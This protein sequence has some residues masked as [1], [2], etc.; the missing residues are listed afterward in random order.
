MLILGL[1]LLLPLQ[2]LTW[3][4]LPR[5]A[6]W[7]PMAFHRALCSVCAV[8]VTVVGTLPTSRPLLIVANHVSWLDIPVLGGHTPLGFLAKREVGEW[9]V[10][11]TFARLQGCLFVDRARKR[12]IPR[13]NEQIAAS[14][15]AGKALVLF[16]EATTGD[17]N[18]LMKFHAPHFQAAIAVAGQAGT[19]TILQPVAINYT[20]RNGLPYTC[21]TRPDIAWYGDMAL[22]PHLW[23]ILQGGPI[24]CCV[25]YGAAMHVGGTDAR[26]RLALAT[27]RT[28]RAMLAN[29]RRGGTD[30]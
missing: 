8:R 28:I 14:I 12:G 18:R 27:Q 3:Y 7:L 16:P 30:L 13:V 2:W 10:I 21:L 9:P 4:F 22:L 24:D 11:G 29:S 20:R 19:R 17:G 25:T 1:A 5:I 26:K 23:E 6:H 15:Q